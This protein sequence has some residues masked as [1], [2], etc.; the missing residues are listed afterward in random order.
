M[1]DVY[2]IP[3]QGSKQQEPSG[4]LGLLGTTLAGEG[5]NNISDHETLLIID[6]ESQIKDLGS[7]CELS[8][9]HLGPVSTRSLPKSLNSQVTNKRSRKRRCSENTRRKEYSRAARE[10]EMQP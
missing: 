7:K 3:V 6:P 10:L 5:Y 4:K 2:A 8:V 1:G 9:S